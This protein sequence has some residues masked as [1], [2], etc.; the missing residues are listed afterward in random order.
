MGGKDKI[1]GRGHNR[2]TSLVKNLGRTNI[3]RSVLYYDKLL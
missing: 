3:T 2:A 1:K